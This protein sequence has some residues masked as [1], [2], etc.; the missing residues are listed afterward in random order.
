MLGRVLGYKPSL[1]MGADRRSRDRLGDD[2]AERARRYRQ[3]AGKPLAAGSLWSDWSQPGIALRRTIGVACL[4]ALTGCQ[5][6]DGL[7]PTASGP[8][9]SEPPQPAA[10][11]REYP[12]LHTVPP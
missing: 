5:S 10:A 11:S 9:A 8:V 4:V 2:R 7:W 6:L 12:S 3:C 1:V